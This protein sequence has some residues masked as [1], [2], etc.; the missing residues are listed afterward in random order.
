M[1]NESSGSLRETVLGYQAT[2]VTPERLSKVYWNRNVVKVKFSSLATQLI[3]QNENFLCRQWRKSPGL[4]LI[5][6]LG[7]NFN[8]ILTEIYI[9][10]F[11]KMHVKLSIGNWRLFCLGLNVLM[12]PTNPPSAGDIANQAIMWVYFGM[13]CLPPMRTCVPEEDI[14]GMHK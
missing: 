4:L 11:K 8:V 9:F 14:Q 10:S 5:G 6:P 12:H 1:D 2:H 3:C 7:T 13:R